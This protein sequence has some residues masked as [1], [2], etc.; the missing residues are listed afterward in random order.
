MDSDDARPDDG[1]AID[2]G[3]SLTQWIAALRAE[4][5]ECPLLDDIEA[6][7]NCRTVEIQRLQGQCEAYSSALGRIADSVTIARRLALPPS[8]VVALD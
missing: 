6:A 2:L 1:G 5:G 3:R 7:V 4:L 8:G